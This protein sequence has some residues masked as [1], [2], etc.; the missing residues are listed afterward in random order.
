MQYERLPLLALQDEQKKIQT[1]DAAFVSLAGIISALQTPATSLTGSTAFLGV[2]ATSSN[3]ALASVVAGDD[4]IVG[5]YDVSVTQLAK[6]QVTPS[7]NGYAASTDVAATGGSISFTINGE[8]TEAITVTAST[9]LAELADLINDQ[10]SGVTA[11]VVN[12]GTNHRLVITSRETG[13]TNGFTINNSLSNSSGQAVAFAVGQI[14]TTGNAQNA[15]NALLNV[16][17]VAIQSASNTVSGA[18]PGVTMTLYN[19]GSFSVSATRDYTSVKDDLQALVAQYN[20]LRQFYTSQAKGP[21][22]TDPLMRGIMNDLKTVFLTPNS[23]GGRYRYLSEIGLELTSSGELILDEAKFDAAVGSYA[24]DVQKL[25]QGSG[26]S[27]GVFDTFLA[28]L[29]NLDGD[30]GLIR[31]TRD[32]IETTLNRY[33]DRIE[34][35]EQRLEIR[36][37]ALMK[38]YAAADQAISQLNQVTASLQNLQRTF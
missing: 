8:T 38:L 18:M 6:A 2:K 16:S 22:G 28:T 9:T 13:E 3:T 26:G 20:K 17:G 12:D 32:N 31:T 7:T 34:Q 21:L 15:Q 35:Q 11:S 24:G 4:A 14:P 33:D 36:R 25:F 19:T 10:G 5:H 30:A 37:L 29:N 1:K 27:N 23:N